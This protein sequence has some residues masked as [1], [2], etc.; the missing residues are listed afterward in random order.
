MDSKK[1]KST[2]GETPNMPPGFDVSESEGKLNSAKKRKRGS[3]RE[4]A[5]VLPT[6]EDTIVNEKPKK[7]KKKKRD[8]D[9]G[10]A[11]VE[12]IANPAYPSAPTTDGSLE[13]KVSRKENKKRLKT[14]ETETLVLASS[15]NART[16]SISCILPVSD[17][18]SLSELASGSISAKNHSPTG[19]GLP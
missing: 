11:P 5:V 16:S 12:R 6:E 18:S 2:I 14:L 8:R 4:A 3:G 1:V 9:P 7:Q 15:S 13:A 17:L 19:R 10:A